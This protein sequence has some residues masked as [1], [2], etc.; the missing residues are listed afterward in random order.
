MH[1]NTQN[2]AKATII[3]SGERSLIVAMKVRQ[4]LEKRG[5]FVEVVNARFVKPIDKEFLANLQSEYVVTIEDNV[6]LG[7]LGSLVNGELIAMEKAC[8]IK[9]FAYRDEFIPQGKVGQLQ[10]DYGVNCLEIEEY[11]S[12]VLS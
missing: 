6:F 5:K 1:K 10:C 9:N 8:K 7:G 12:R 2:P 3:A 4:N 11:L